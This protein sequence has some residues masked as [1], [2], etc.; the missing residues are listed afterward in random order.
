MPHMSLMYGDI[1][2]GEKLKAKSLL[3][4]HWPEI[5]TLEFEV[6]GLSLYSTDPSDKQLT[7]WEK[8]AESTLQAHSSAD[9]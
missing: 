3:L 7:T 5:E 4:E 8:V 2:E 1:P 6:K 9:G